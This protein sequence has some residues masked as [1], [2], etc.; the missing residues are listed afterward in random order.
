MRSHADLPLLRIFSL[1]AVEPLGAGL[2]D[3]HSAV[4]L[5][6]KPQKAEPIAQVAP[7]IA[8]SRG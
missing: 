4:G 6:R 7:V 1:V 3:R 5:P 8:V 2:K